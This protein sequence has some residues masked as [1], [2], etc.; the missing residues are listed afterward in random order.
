[1]RLENEFEVNAPVEQVWQVLEDVPR[2]ARCMPG[3]ELIS[4]DGNQHE[5]TVKA[6]LGPMR[7]TYQGTATVTEL[8]S[9]AHRAAMTAEGRETRGQGRA[10]AEV[11]LSAEEQ[12]G[13][14]KV[15]IVTDLDI[16]GR[17]AQFGRGLLEDVSTQ[18]ID[19]FAAQLEREVV[20]AGAEPAAAAAPGAD[21]APADDRGPTTPSAPSTSPNGA[22]D[23]ID[24]GSL[25]STVAARPAVAFSGGVLL[26]LLLGWLF[27]R[28]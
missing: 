25:L 8:D 9:S 13:R 24:V 5:G 3:A 7:V 16:T 1:M 20:G 4:S 6:R 26:G 21:A 15:A 14:T 19:D 11:S 23:A 22:S 18:L 17:V 12:D 27:G 2:V 10:K 28:R